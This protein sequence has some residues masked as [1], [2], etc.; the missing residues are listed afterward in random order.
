MWNFW[1]MLEDL[2]G[3]GDD[4]HVVLGAQFAGHGPEDAGALGIAVFADDDDGIGIESGGSCHPH[5][6]TGRACGR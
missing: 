1:A 2:G 6:A 4:L 5:G 3:E